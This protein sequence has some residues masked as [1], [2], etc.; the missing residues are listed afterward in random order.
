MRKTQY[1]AD[2]D[3]LTG[4]ANRALMKTLLA[5]RLVACQRNSTYL[6]LL[7]IDLDGFKKINDNHGHAVGDHLLQIV[8]H[9]LRALIRT[10]DV[11]A[12]LGGDEF[13]VVLAGT[14]ARD[15]ELIAA[16]IIDSLGAPY[17]LGD[18]VAAISASI[19][20]AQYPLSGSSG[21]ALLQRADDAMYRAKQDGKSRF[22]WAPD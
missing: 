9:R 2:H 8:A 22:S 7:Y 5:E 1:Q 3:A 18:C 14:S 17:K 10:S 6:S 21:K 15:A 11:I 13:V 16:K 19:G 12:R 4:L 20:L